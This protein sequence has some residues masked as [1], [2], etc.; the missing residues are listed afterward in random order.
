MCVGVCR[1]V[2]VC[3][4]VCGCCCC[5]CVCVGVCVCVCMCVYVCII[6]HTICYI[7]IYIYR[8]QWGQTTQHKNKSGQLGPCF[9]ESGISN[10]PQGQVQ[11]HDNCMAPKWIVNVLVLPCVYLVLSQYKAVLYQSTRA[12]DA[13]YC[14]NDFPKPRHE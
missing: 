9:V 1:C 4:C 3:V 8:Y 2:C 7:C 11:V 14:S 13:L 6:T 12:S 10:P 5:C